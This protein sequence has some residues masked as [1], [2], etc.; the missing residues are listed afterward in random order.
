MVLSGG[1]GTPVYDI[2]CCETGVTFR[3]LEEAADAAGES[4]GCLLRSCEN[5][6]VTCGGY[7]WRRRVFYSKLAQESPAEDLLPG[8]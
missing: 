7:T 2:V 5:P 6:G 8:I 4:V 1:E 3:S